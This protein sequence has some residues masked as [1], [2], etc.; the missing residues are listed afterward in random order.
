ML[1]VGMAV[2]DAHVRGSFLC[3]HVA[4]HNLC[5]TWEI[6]P[7]PCGGRE[8][9]SWVR[10]CL[11][12]NWTV[13]WLRAYSHQLVR[14]RLCR[15]VLWL[16]AS[17]GAVTRG[18]PFSSLVDRMR[19]LHCERNVASDMPWFLLA[20][21]STA[22]SVVLVVTRPL[23]RQFLLRP[24]A[25]KPCGPN[26]AMPQLL[27]TRWTVV[28][29]ACGTQRAAGKCALGV[30]HTL[31]EGRCMGA[32]LLCVWWIWATHS[33]VCVAFE[34]SLASDDTCVLS[35]RRSW[36]RHGNGKFDSNPFRKVAAAKE[37]GSSLVRPPMRIPL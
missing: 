36:S 21:A 2:G 24:S 37:I 10:S 7:D 28:E 15:T 1:S 3:A 27:R 8:G 20:W 23:S 22:F 9:H 18:F 25:P 5:R 32:P 13:L 34:N 35:L 30:S 4:A 29:W 11:F 14:S 6:Q 12:L 26:A 16:R 33:I 17:S 19:M 31:H